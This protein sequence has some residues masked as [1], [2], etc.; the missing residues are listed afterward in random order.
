[1]ENEIVFV[2]CT[3]DDDYLDECRYYIEKLR[4]PEG[5]SVSVVPIRNPQSMTSGYNDALKQAKAKYKIFLHQDVFIV[6]RDFINEIISCFNKD[7]NIGII[8][9]AGTRKLINAQAWSSLDVGGCYSIGTFSGL[10][11][12]GVKPDISDPVGEYEEADYVDGML[13][14][15]SC[16]IDWDERIDAFHFYDLSQCIRYRE[17]GLKTVVIKQGEPWIFHDFGPLNLET[18]YQNKMNFCKWYG[19]DPGDENDDKKLYHLCETIA[20]TLK[21]KINDRSM[22]EVEK[23]LDD[24]GN[25]IYF[26][27]DLLI[28]YFSLEISA[29]EYEFD[30][31]MFLNTEDSE[32]LW[33]VIEKKWNRMKWDWIRV[34]FE[35]EAPEY[36]VNKIIKGEYSVIAMI[37]SAIHCV[38]E[39]YSRIIRDVGEHISQKGYIDLDVWEDML[40]YIREY[41]RVH[42]PSADGL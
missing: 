7:D 22:S 39:E 24:V 35:Y 13:M 5:V 20:D 36:I 32:S 10:G 14:A 40:S 34:M 6:N 29:L 23:I 16:D 1:M 37:V 9:I 19:Y 4:M 21:N 2:I 33:S 3:N 38:P 41:E 30:I 12:V 8:G 28:I 27:Q 17:K 25:A 31:R 26:N 18:Y 42:V 15:T 11:L